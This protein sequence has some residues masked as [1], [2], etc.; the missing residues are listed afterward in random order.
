MPPGAYPL[1]IP[2]HLKTTANATPT[3]TLYATV[4]ATV[5]A[6]AHFW[7]MNPTSC[8]ARGSQ[9][10]PFVPSPVAMTLWNSSCN[11]LGQGKAGNTG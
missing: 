11:G 1:C 7:A 5:N 9:L 2:M 3:A 6:S 10:N 8:G 4:N